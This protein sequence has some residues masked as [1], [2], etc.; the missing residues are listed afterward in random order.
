MRRYAR[1]LTKD[2]LLKNGITAITEDGRVFKGEEEMT[3]YS[4]KGTEYQEPYLGI[5]I[6]DED[7]DGNK[8]KI[9]REG[10]YVRKDGSVRAYDSYVYRMRMIGLH[11]VMWAWFHGEVPD[12][13]VVD[14]IDNKHGILSD[15]RLSNLQL[16]TPA[17]NLAKERGESTK[18][19]KC[20]VDRPRSYYEDKLNR[21][22]EE[23][24][25]AKRQ[26]D[27]EKCHKLRTN[28]AQTKARIR[29]WDFYH[30]AKKLDES[31]YKEMEEYYK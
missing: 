3:Y 21:Y 24:E 29:Y 22:T 19:L 9:S 7:E 8:I 26:H 6:Y 4:I 11:R 12:G 13:Y 16:L 31:Y 10:R 25:Q 15:Y 14:H 28:L 20:K 2:D 27:A 5:S 23:H 17:E 30:A 18:M 1:R